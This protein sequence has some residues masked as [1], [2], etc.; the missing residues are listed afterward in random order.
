MKLLEQFLFI[1]CICGAQTF[2]IWICFQGLNAK[3][4]CGR[5]AARAWWNSSGWKVNSW[6]LSDC[7]FK[8]CEK[9]SFY[10]CHVKWKTERVSWDEAAELCDRLEKSQSCLWLLQVLITVSE[11]SEQLE[12]TVLFEHAGEE[13]TV[14]P[15]VEGSTPG[16][17]WVKRFYGFKQL[18]IKQK[19]QETDWWC[20]LWWFSLLDSYLQIWR[21]W[22]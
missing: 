4:R 9:F 22:V 17:A 10:I 5:E 8:S 12:G 6:T 18:L 1:K 20:Q 16:A 15:Q 13:L 2:R 11:K 14:G 21:L 7:W 3:T 19:L